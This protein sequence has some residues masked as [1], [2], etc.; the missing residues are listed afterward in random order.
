MT[1]APA[2]TFRFD[3][4]AVRTSCADESH[5]RWLEEFLAPHF[6]VVA[7]DAYDQS[8]SLVFDA[9][10]HRALK[11]RGPAGALVPAFVLD[12]GVLELP[13]WRGDTGAQALHDPQFDVFYV[14]DGR[15]VT[16]VARASRPAL[17]TPLMR[18]VRELAMGHARAAGGFFLHA[19]CFATSAGAVITAAPSAFGKTTFLF[20]ALHAPQARYV[21]NDRL[22]VGFDARG[23][24]VR[25]MPTVVSVREGTFEFFPHVKT[26][27]LARRFN[28]RSTLAE[29]AD[30]GGPAPRA[31]ENGCLGLTPAQVCALLGTGR[32][33]G[34]RARTVLIPRITGAPGGI[35]LAPIAPARACEHVEAA[36]FGTGHVDARS[37]A[38]LPAVAPPAGAVPREAP[39]ALCARLA[40]SVPCFEV[41]VGRQAYDDAPSFL[42]L[43]ERALGAVA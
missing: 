11:E 18:V 38:F 17:R 33:A 27:L 12:R 42:S 14:I 31:W 36:L 16:V 20:F 35:A 34:A 43:I 24:H 15:E 21:T 8:V 6:E 29:A 30:P 39:Q 37:H 2:R 41:A 9:A 19:S 10:R 5:L 4:L 7:E 32:V 3:G 25:G 22:L 28:S 13:L 26:A 1:A 23:A 40:S